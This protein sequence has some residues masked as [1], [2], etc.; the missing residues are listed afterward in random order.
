[1]QAKQ[2]TGECIDSVHHGHD[3]LVSATRFKRH[4]TTHQEQL[5]IFALPR[6]PEE[7]GTPDSTSVVD[8]VSETSEDL[9]YQEHDA[10]NRVKDDSHVSLA[11]QDDASQEDAGVPTRDLMEEDQPHSRL[12]EQLG[13]MWFFD[14]EDLQGSFNQQVGKRIHAHAREDVKDNL[15]NSNKGRMAEHEESTA[16]EQT[17]YKREAGSSFSL[18]LDTNAPPD[19]QFDHDPNGE[20]DEDGTTE[21]W[22]T[23]RY[24]ISDMDGGERTFS[25]PST[26]LANME[27]DPNA[28]VNTVFQCPNPDCT[29]CFRKRTEL[30]YGYTLIY[31]LLHHDSQ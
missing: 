30:R 9:V 23:G 6:A 12:D 31:H 29:R 25:G 3:I 13:G 24:E 8:S 15:F 22:E 18:A 26:A 10:S 20:M 2:E 11:D 16:A 21:T 1:M 4:V 14:Q 19:A 17:N 7:E 27:A 5:A 28:I